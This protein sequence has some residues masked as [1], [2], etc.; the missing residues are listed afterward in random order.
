MNAFRQKGGAKTILLWQRQGGITS[1]GVDKGQ[2]LCQ[3]GGQKSKE[4]VLVRL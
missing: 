4:G 2:I 1:W 3:V